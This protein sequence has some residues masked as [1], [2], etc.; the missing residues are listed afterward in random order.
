MS[1]V[2]R[3]PGPWGPSSVTEDLTP[4]QVDNNFWELVQQIA[5]KAVQGVGI[6]N[7]I[8][9][10]NQMTILLTDHTLLGP[11]TLPVAAISF[12]GEW[13]PNTDYLANDIITHGG[14]TYIVLWNHTSAATFDPGA[15]DGMGHDYYGLLLQNAATTIPP[16]GANGAFLRKLGILDYV[17]QWTTAALGDLSD[18]HVTSP[19]PVTGNV[20]TFSGGVWIPAPL[21]AASIALEQLSDVII[22]ESPALASGQLLTYDAD[23]TAWINAPPHFDVTVVGPIPGELVM[24]DGTKWVNTLNA[25]IPVKTGVNVVGALTLDYSLGSVQR[26]VMTNGVTLNAVIN[27]P[28]AGQLGRL[29]LE[30]RNTGAFTWT[31]PTTWRWPGGSVP[32]VSVN[33]R[34]IYAVTSFDGGTTIDACVIGQNYL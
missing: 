22:M 1:I 24:Y 4:N 12:R 16:G 3:T 27:W 7:I 32:I 13:Q 8:V 30:I 34:D 10:G 18:V 15:N 11:F 5:A 2:Y 17:A 31:W 21:A 19:A 9:V 20:L 23:L 29:L 26:L 25:N 28:P 14:S 33:G 6:A